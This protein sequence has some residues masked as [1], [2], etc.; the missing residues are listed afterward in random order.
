VIVVL[1]FR[2]AAIYHYLVRRNVWICISVG[3]LTVATGFILPKLS[4]APMPIK[5]FMFE[6]KSVPVSI[7]KELG[8][9]VKVTSVLKAG[10]PFE[11]TIVKV[12]VDISSYL[13]RHYRGETRRLTSTSAVCSKSYKLSHALRDYDI[14]S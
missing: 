12:A 7:S 2:G 13:E 8:A 3:K 14:R 11:L 9:A 5:K 1:A 10:A 6:V 4:V